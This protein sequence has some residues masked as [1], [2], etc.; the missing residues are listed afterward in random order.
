M[1]RVKG[2]GVEG[3]VTE[4]EVE[5]VEVRGKGT[6]RLIP[7]DTDSTENISQRTDTASW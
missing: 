6:S 1:E 7:P 2:S 3:G 5:V 4:E